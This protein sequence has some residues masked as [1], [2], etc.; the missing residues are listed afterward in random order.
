MSTLPAAVIPPAF[1]HLVDDAAIFPPGLAPLPDAVQAHVAHLASGYA[2]LVGPFIVDAARLDE[3]VPLAPSGF[4][5][6]VVVPDADAVDEVVRRAAGSIALAGL[7]V[8]L[9]GGALVPQVEAVAAAAPE[10][11][12][13]YVEVPRPTH[14][15]WPAV[16]RA[17]ARGG[18]RLKFRTGGTEAAAFPSEAEVATWITAAVAAGVAF[19]CTAGLHHAVRHTGPDTG[20]EHHGYLNVLLA[21]ARAAGGADTGTVE[22]ALRERSGATVAAGLDDLSDTER[23]AARAAF[24]SY[25]SCSV[26]E[27]LEDLRD[28]HLLTPGTETA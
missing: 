26:L 25:G 20:F 27:P 19:K 18:L 14:E 1:R 8:K 23:A 11:V 12:P 5:A 9:V 10:D 24:T 15:E 3:L 17:V 22:D 13:T 2:D 4:A 16:L 21:T 7:E 28:L 6:S